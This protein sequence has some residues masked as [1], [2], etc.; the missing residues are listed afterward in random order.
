VL[1]VT[2]GH[3]AG[4]PVLHILDSTDPAEV[5]A[6]ELLADPAEKTTVYIV[7]S[8]PGSTL[9]PNIFKQDFFEEQGN[10]PQH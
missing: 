3:Q 4:F 10:L 9:E 2:F 1:S 6:V 8:K 7:S 5:K